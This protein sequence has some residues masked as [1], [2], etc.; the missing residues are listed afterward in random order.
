MSDQQARRIAPRAAFPGDHWSGFG[1]Q[2]LYLDDLL[3]IYDVLAAYAPESPSFKQDE[4]SHASGTWLPPRH[5]PSTSPVRGEMPAP[6]PYVHV[7]INGAYEAESRAQISGFH[8]KRIESIAMIVG[9]FDLRFEVNDWGGT[10]VSRGTD[11]GVTVAAYNDI[12][13]ILE[14]R[15]PWWTKWFTGARV[16]NALIIALV[17]LS[18]LN[19]FRTDRWLA[20]A[21]FADAAMLTYLMVFWSTRNRDRS[22]V[23]LKYKDDAPNRFMDIAKDVATSTLKTAVLAGLAIVGALLLGL[24][25]P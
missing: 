20:I 11:D 4:E 12:V 3:E 24:L 15:V 13:K 14:R 18:A 25:R 6:T 9:S 16:R 21:L 17:G 7:V 19:L 10:W 2:R 8:L 5:R 23:I 1:I 22:K